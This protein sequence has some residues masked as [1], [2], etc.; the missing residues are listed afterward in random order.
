MHLTSVLNSIEQSAVGSTALQVAVVILAVIS[1]P[2][3]PRQLRLILHTWPVKFVFLVLVIYISNHSPSL[4][5]FTGILIFLIL[6]HTSTLQ[7]KAT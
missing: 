4:A 2:Q 5:L 1:A 6:Q 3:L 7:S